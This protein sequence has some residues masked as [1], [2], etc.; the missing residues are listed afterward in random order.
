MHPVIETALQRLEGTTP[1]RTDCGLR[2]GAR[3]CSG[4]GDG[5]MLLFAGEDCLLPQARLQ[6]ALLPGYGKVTLLRCGGHCDRALRPLAC[7]IFPLAPRAC[8]DG[9]AVRMDLRGR[10]VC[11]LTHRPAS[12]LQ[13][14]FVAAVQAA[15]DGIAAWPEGRRYLAALSR[16]VDRYRLDLS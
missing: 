5:G 6:E 15:L 12:A 4:E 10:A 1:L 7:R 13:R 8:G 9:F 2:C 14:P 16:E 11:P 3:C